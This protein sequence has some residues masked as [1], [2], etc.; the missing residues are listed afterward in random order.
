MPVAAVPATLSAQVPADTVAAVMPADAY[1][2]AQARE[3]VRLARERRAMV[4]RRIE[5]YQTTAHE[6]MTAGL[7]AGLAERLLFRRETVSR[8]DW[9]RDTVRIDVLAAREVVPPVT[10][11]IAVPG[12]LLSYAPALAFE[13]V[14][15]EMLL[16]LD[17]TSVRHPLAAGSEAHYRFSTGDTTVI[18]LPDG[19]LVRLR[20]L[21][22]QPR[23]R[24]PQLI[25]GSFW[26][27]A[28]THAVVQAFFR[29]ARAYDSSVDGNRSLLGTVRADVEVVAIDYGLWDFRWWLPR[30]MVAQGVVQFGAFRLP[31]SFER[32]YDDYTVV[33][34]TL[35]APTAL[36]EGE[37][38]LPR[39]CRPPV[40]LAVTTQAGGTTPSDSAFAAR[41]AR[42][43]S[44]RRVRRDSLRAVRTAQRDSALLAGDTTVAAPA[45]ECE[46]AFIVTHAPRSELLTSER[47]PSSIYS[48]G[49]GFMLPSEVDAIIRRA[50]AIAPPPWQLA[51]PQLA[52]GPR[53]PGLLR[54][55]RVEGL[56]VGARAV[57]DF[58]R[59]GAEAEARI[60]TE[61]E[62]GARFGV[63]RESFRTRTGVAAY[64][65][66]DVV[67][68]S[69][70]AFGM[71]SSLAALLLGRDDNDYFRATGAE[72]TVTPSAVRSQW[73]AL[74]LFAERQAAVETGTSFSARR[75]LDSDRVFRDNV[76]AA[77]ADQLGAAL[78]L[79][80]S[81]GLDPNAPRV[82]AELQLLSETGD[83]TFV[84]PA[85]VLRAMMPLGRRLAL[86]LE[87]AGGSGFGDVPV[88]R[89]FQLGG[90]GSLRGYDA[91]TLRGDTYLRGLAELGIGLPFARF[92]LFSDIGWA[93]ERDALRQARPLRGAGG[94]VVLLDGVLRFDLA[95][96]LD[97]GQ[98]RVHMQ[99]AR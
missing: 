82:A 20:E 25:N 88:Q 43:D 65:R 70:S 61:G 28:G 90:A 45:P 60:G 67:E 3:L 66:L 12:D 63:H 86:T 52:W 92:A 97:S 48:D 84:R 22:F 42:Q 64:R 35:G 91:A 23:R 98:W 21:R 53:G 46:R 95:R 71:G 77:A 80:A 24:D 51:R 76:A 93:G 73:W 5:R 18:R 15:S 81:A 72:L 34:D 29:L 94:G 8:I 54:Y 75:L 96:G 50:R 41:V 10:G 40:T 6:R 59:L 58:G 32:R 1:L 87:G 56:S 57:M 7:R 49:P 13:P 33:G 36:A 30:S 39:P 83:Y 31:M 78:Q 79:R 9:T 69:P 85:A 55:N 37:A 47:L 99:F 19:R 62:V 68:V 16:R 11:G 89:H 44:V 74:R 2:D 17:S 27:E 38:P 14:D 4:D 26:L